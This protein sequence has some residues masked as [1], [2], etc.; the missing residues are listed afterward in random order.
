MASRARQ[1]LDFTLLYML[2][3]IA[4]PL[5]R[6]WLLALGRGF[7][8]LIWYVFRF[9]RTIVLD[10][11][12]NAF[13][14]EQDKA[15]I[16]NVAREF[17]RNLGMTLMEFMAMPRLSPEELVQLVDIEGREHLDAIVE[18]G[19]G[20]VLVSGHFGNFAYLTARLAA[21]VGHISFVAKSQSNSRIDTLLNRIW[22]QLG[23]GIIGPQAIKEMIRALRRHEFI[24]MLADQNAGPEGVLCT[25][26]GRPAYVFRGPAYLSW[27]LDVPLVTGHIYRRADGRHIIRAD[28][29]I[30]PDRSLPEEHAVRALTEHHVRRLEEAVRRAPDQY[31]WVHRRWKAGPA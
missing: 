26:L 16:R 12:Q 2:F 6:R 1:W 11:L 17:Y 28:P 18:D 8:S 15:S 13:G 14:G 10:N 30:Y 5:P 23:V 3:L 22:R 27:K 24:G 31:Y 29:P 7:G 9:R 25:F 20:A 4:R 19:R 21:E